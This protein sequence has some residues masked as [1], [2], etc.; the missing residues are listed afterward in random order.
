MENVPAVRSF[1]DSILDFRH[2]PM[3]QMIYELGCRL[4]EFARIQLKDVDFSRSSVLIPAGGPPE[5]RSPRSSCPI[6][7][8]SRP[9]P[10][11]ENRIC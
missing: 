9:G 2:K 1:L 8:D 10:Y 6:C 4:D 3:V 7:P 11:S 5:A